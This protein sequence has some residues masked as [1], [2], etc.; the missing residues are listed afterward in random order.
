MAEIFRVSKDVNKA[1]EEIVKKIN[2]INRKLLEDP[3]YEKVKDYQGASGSIRIEE[4]DSGSV[5]IKVKTKKGW[6]TIGS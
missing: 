3:S 4:T 5:V 2:E 1:I 6:H